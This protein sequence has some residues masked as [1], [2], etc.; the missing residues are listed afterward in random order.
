ME[1]IHL[2]KEY[3][4]GTKFPYDGADLAHYL[5]DLYLTDR[6]MEERSDVLELENENDS[7]S[8]NIGMD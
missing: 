3:A 1:R 6:L 8:I 7:V 4:G 5:Y 2:D